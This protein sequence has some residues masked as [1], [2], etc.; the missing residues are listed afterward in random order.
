MHADNSME[1]ADPGARPKGMEILKARTEAERSRLSRLHAAGELHRIRPNTYMPAT[2]WNGLDDT[3]RRRILHLTAAD[4]RPGMVLVG[5]SAAIAH[6]LDVL[7]IPTDRGD[8]GSAD[9]PSGPPALAGP[10][11]PAERGVVELA[12]P[13]R[14]RSVT[15]GPI[16]ERR[17][18]WGP[19]DV[20]RID[21]RAVVSP[22]AAIADIQER[23]GPAHALVAADSA[24]RLGHPRSDL[25]LA[26]ER[27]R[28][29]VAAL[30]TV[31]LASELADSAAE[32]L[33]R[34]NIIEAGL[35]PPELQ[36]WV[37]NSDGVLVGRPD[38]AYRRHLVIIEFHGEI[39]FSGRYGDPETRF[40]HEWRRET[41]LLSL[42][43]FVVRVSWPEL[44]DGT[45]ISR[46]RETLDRGERAIRTGAAFNG[47]FVRAGEKWPPGFRTRKQDID[48]RRAG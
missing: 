3:A 28:C 19:R 16:R 29:P 33:L 2:R 42:G 25:A 47:T 21:G 31:A 11:A 36:P 41:E 46:I 18:R 13:T 22:G 35:P 6:G 24:L 34:S 9:R 5:R 15:V 37:F 8:G 20:V 23:H 45:A 4:I 38:L 7:D 1:P 27:G 44:F 40:R 32:S 26:A 30:K 43:L 48:A 17:L 10:N 12:H 39:K 14:R